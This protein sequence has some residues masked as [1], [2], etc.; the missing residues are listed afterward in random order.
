MYL[1]HEEN[2]FEMPT[3]K[4]RRA[5]LLL[6]SQVASFVV[7]GCD[8]HLWIF[9]MLLSGLHSFREKPSLGKAQLE[10]LMIFELTPLAKALCQGACLRGISAQ[11]CATAV[12]LTTNLRYFIGDTGPKF[13][14]A[15]SVCLALCE[16]RQ[17]LG[18]WGFNVVYYLAFQLVAKQLFKQA[19]YLSSK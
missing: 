8:T 10:Y 15:S 16:E 17:G 3:L 5:L 13:L 19:R 4:A 12:L 9:W 18:F 6:Y 2:L 1:L 11:N 14:V 7:F